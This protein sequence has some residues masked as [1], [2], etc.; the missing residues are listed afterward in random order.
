MTLEGFRV[1]PGYE[2]WCITRDAKIYDTK[3]GKRIRTYRYGD[4]MFA[5]YKLKFVDRLIAVHRAVALAWVEN[6]DPVLKTVVNHR[7]GNPMNNWHENLEWTTTSG[8]NFHAV[9][10]GL[11][12]DA[13]P[14]KIRNFYTTEVR[15]FSSISQACEYMKLPESTTLERLRPP[16]FGSLLAGQYEFRLL[17]DPEPFFYEG[18]SQIISPSRYMVEVTHEDGSKRF[19]F[20]NGELMLQ[21]QVYQS[22]YGRSVPALVK[23][24]GEVHPGKTF[25]LRDGEAEIERTGSRKR[26]NSTFRYFP[27]TAKKDGEKLEFKSLRAA[28][29]YFG[30]DRDVIKL[31]VSNPE[32]TFLGWSFE[33][34]PV[35]IQLKKRESKHLAFETRSQENAKPS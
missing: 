30:V 21:Y 35:S 22:P 29:A 24:A 11:R 20:K 7:D 13:R 23:Y 33:G 27:V 9:D 5:N 12:P 15:E 2:N 3:T 19:L 8:N 31:R 28:A 18:R 14:C 1:I 34:K 10:M 32:S 6:D 17:D 16:K 4:R 25:K 26:V